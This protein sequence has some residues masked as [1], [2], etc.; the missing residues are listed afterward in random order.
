MAQIVINADTETDS[1]TVTVDGREITD[2]N[3]IS[4]YL[5]PSCGD[6]DEKELCINIS[7]SV[8]DKESGLRTYTT[9]MAADTHEAETLKNQGAKLSKK[10]KDFIVLK[11]TD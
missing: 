7:S 4:I 10:N 5:S 1:L 9:L 6:S 11:N 2:I 3:A 8:K